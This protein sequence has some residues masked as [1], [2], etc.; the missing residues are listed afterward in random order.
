MDLAFHGA[1]GQTGDDLALEEE[2][3]DEQ[4][5]GR[6]D[7]GCDG[8]HDVAHRL[9]VPRKLA[10]FGIMVWLSW[11]SSIEVTAKSLYPRRKLNRPVVTRQAT[12][13]E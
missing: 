2:D 3:E 4:R 6:R 9:I 7:D 11:L 8:K 13:P 5:H 12:S 1:G 10:I